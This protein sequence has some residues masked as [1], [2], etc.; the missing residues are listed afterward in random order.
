MTPTEHQGQVT[1]APLH[2]CTPVPVHFCTPAPQRG[3]EPFLWPSLNPERTEQKR[4]GTTRAV[5][6]RR[7]TM[8]GRMK[9][10]VLPVS[11]STIHELIMEG[12][13]SQEGQYC[14]FLQTSYTIQVKFQYLLRQR[15]LANSNSYFCS[16]LSHDHNLN[17]TPKEHTH[18]NTNTDYQRREML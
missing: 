9:S 15:F 3:R 10:E 18:T 2:P 6:P 5:T 17:N 12:G 1:S 11:D 14:P 13:K 4:V 8:N 7:N 16:Q